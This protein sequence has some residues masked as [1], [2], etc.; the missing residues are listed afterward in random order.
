MKRKGTIQLREIVITLLLAMLNMPALAQN[1]PRND[2]WTDVSHSRGAPI[3]YDLV[4]PDD[5][6]NEITITFSPE[7]WTAQ[8]AD[9]TEIYGERG[10]ADSGFGRRAGQSRAGAQGR[11]GNP[12]QM[13]AML[14]QIAEQLDRSETQLTAAMQLM[15]DFNAVADA[16]EMEVSEL[17]A[18]LPM[19]GD[20]GFPAGEGMLRGG[21][22]G[23]PENMQLARNPIWVPVT[24]HFSEGVW[25]EVGFRY[26]GNS[27]L[28]IGWGSGETGLPFKL[29][30]DEFEDDNPALDNQRFYGFKQLSFARSLFIDSSLQREKVAADIFRDAGVPSAETA[31]YAVYVDVGAGAGSEFWG[32]YT[33]VELPEDTLIETQFADDNGNMYKPGGPS[34]S[35]AEGTFREGSFDKETNRDSD[36]ADVLAVF[37]ALHSESRQIDPAAWRAGLEAALDVDSFLLWLAVNTFIQNWDTYGNLPHNYYL[38]ADE[39]TGTL[40]WIPWDNNMALSSG[41]STAGG[42]P[43]LMPPLE[44]SLADVDP[45]AHPLIGLLMEAPLYRSRYVELVA[46]VASDIFTPERMTA[47]Y[48]ANF[49]MLA[50]YLRDVGAD[51]D[52]ESLRSAT[53]GLIEHVQQRALAAAEFVLGAD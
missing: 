15:P 24:I 34:A 48:E 10:A 36:Y 2:T 47:I 20:S 49:E 14:A 39:A 13:R 45:A 33:A 40:V 31:F 28:S 38:Y 53:D 29:D 1:T 23:R 8:E 44:L 32:I 3:N 5:R 41:A 43:G 35:F 37:A 30:F 11:A 16:L 27:T 50:N 52:L 22:G 42:A 19:P 7:A 18:A 4:L 6:I 21:E 17:F 51:A 12:R 46:L 25:E 9:M 26:K